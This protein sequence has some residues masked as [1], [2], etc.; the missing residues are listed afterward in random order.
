MSL[1]SKIMGSLF[2]D[3]IPSI[4]RQTKWPVKFVHF[5]K[6]QLPQVRFFNTTII[7]RGDEEWLIARRA[8]GCENE[9]M[10]KNTL[11][12]FKLDDNRSP[13]HFAPIHL[14]TR[15]YR[16]QHFEDPRITVI[17]GR[18]W[19]SYCTFQI[20]K[21]ARYTGAHQQVAI[22]NDDWQPETRWDPV[23]GKNGGSIHTGDGNEKNWTWF[24]HEGKLHL[25]YNIEPHTVVEWHGDAVKAEH[26]TQT[27]PWDF[28]HMRGGTSPV[29]LDKGG[30]FT[31]FFHSSTKWKDPKRRYHMGAYQFESKPPFKITRMTSKPILSG[32]QHDPW[33]PGLPLVVFPCGAIHKKGKWVISMGVNDFCTAIMELP[34]NDLM[35]LMTKVPQ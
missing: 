8:E 33:Q 5:G 34:H 12:A 27:L 23:Y 13:T 18:P 15:S 9:G 29:Q 10:G 17:G 2:E 22:L 26:L 28:G 20:F 4:T 25:L 21:P 7:A 30:D 6:A 1:V 19:L 3:S 16:D 14:D 35:K 24:E 31:V 32:S 11:M